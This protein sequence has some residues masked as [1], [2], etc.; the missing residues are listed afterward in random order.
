MIVN[1]TDQNAFNEL[2]AITGQQCIIGEDIPERYFEPWRGKIGSAIAIVFPE[3]IEH[4][5]KTITWAKN[6]CYRLLPQGARTGLVD[7]SVPSKENSENSVIVSFE[8]YRSNMKINVQDQRL[9][10]DAGFLL[11]EVNEYLKTFG[12]FLPVNVSSDPMV[13]AMASTNI[14][15]APLSRTASAVAKKVCDGN[16][17]SSPITTSRASK[18]KNNALVPDATPT[19]YLLPM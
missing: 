12:Y 11:S 19:Q 17:T 15:V 8:K 10:V 13:G 9:I 6:E 7:A 5:Q 4:I 3:S 2:C 1:M 18:L 16:I 14:G